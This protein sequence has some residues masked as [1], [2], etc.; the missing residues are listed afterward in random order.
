MLLTAV[1][2]ASGLAGLLEAGG[3]AAVAALAAG[4]VIYS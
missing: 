3:M 2:G 1:E 4:G